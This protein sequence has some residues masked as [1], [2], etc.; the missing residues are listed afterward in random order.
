[1]ARLRADDDEG[2]ASAGPGPYLTAV[3]EAAHSVADYR[4]GFSPAGCSIVPG[5]E[6]EGSA[7]SLDSHE[8]FMTVAAD[9]VLEHDEEK[10]RGQLIVFHAGYCATVLAG[11]DERPART[12]AES[13]FD[14]AEKLRQTY[15]PAVSQAEC[16]EEAFE[17]VR[18]PKN[19]R[20]IEAVAAELLSL[21]RLDGD[22]VAILCDIVDRECERADLERFRMMRDRVKA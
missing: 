9:G 20:A 13:D 6:N 22:E 8:T 18:E 4:F 10:V 7:S 3:H 17:F 21:K 14:R 2:S 1:M 19:W 5:A 15:R 16:V 11:E 12:G